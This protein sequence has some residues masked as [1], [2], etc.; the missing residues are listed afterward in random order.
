MAT[1]PAEASRTD[2]REVPTAW[3]G[4]RPGRQDGGPV[5][6]TASFS[7]LWDWSAGRY[8]F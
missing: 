2:R 6:L 3:F 5:G 1:I 8:T 4:F 7:G